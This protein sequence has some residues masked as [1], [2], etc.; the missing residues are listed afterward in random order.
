VILRLEAM[1]LKENGCNLD[2]RQS[3]QLSENLPESQIFFSSF[4]KIAI[5]VKCI[6]QNFTKDHEIY[7][8]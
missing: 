2:E 4:E 1:R 6:L 7:E 8:S 3:F 5:E